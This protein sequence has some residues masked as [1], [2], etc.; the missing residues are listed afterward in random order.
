M[1]CLGKGPTLCWSEG[2]SAGRD[3]VSGRKINLACIGLLVQMLKYCDGKRGETLTISEEKRKVWG[4]NNP[5]EKGEINRRSRDNGER[6][7][8][9]SKNPYKV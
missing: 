4:I 8:K 6:G 7:A 5:T 1:E 3:R 2:P 9:L